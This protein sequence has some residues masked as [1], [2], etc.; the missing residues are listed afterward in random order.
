MVDRAVSVGT[1]TVVVVSLGTGASRAQ[2]DLI[3]V[4]LIPCTY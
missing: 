3:T 1:L 4:L 2:S